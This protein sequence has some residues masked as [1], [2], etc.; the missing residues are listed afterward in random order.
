M[1]LP[2]AILLAHHRHEVSPTKISHDATIGAGAIILPGVT[3]GPNAVV[4]AGAVVTKDVQEGTVVSGI[5]LTTRPVHN[6]NFSGTRQLRGI[7][8]LWDHTALIF[9]RHTLLYCVLM[10]RWRAS[11]RSGTLTS[12]GL[13]LL[14]LCVAPY[15]LDVAICEDSSAS[16][17]HQPALVDGEEVDPSETAAVFLSYDDQTPSVILLSSPAEYQGPLVDVVTLTRPHHF[18]CVSLTSR[19]PPFS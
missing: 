12:C 10:L 7:R 8:W 16:P 11:S 5:H 18:A 14:V 15:L 19:P 9:C 17:L 4:G 2:G 6:F 1:G 13:C 3:I